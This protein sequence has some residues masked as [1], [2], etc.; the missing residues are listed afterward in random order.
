MTIAMHLCGGQRPTL[1]V[2]K[3][4][5]VLHGP[6]VITICHHDWIFAVVGLFLTWILW[7]E[8]IFSNLP[9]NY[10]PDIPPCF[11]GTACI[12]SSTLATYSL[13]VEF[14]SF[15]RH[16]QK[17]FVFKVRGVLLDHSNSKYGL[18]LHNILTIAH[19]QTMVSVK[20]EDLET[21]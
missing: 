9:L 2:I 20:I 21:K 6:G 15:F 1:D 4:Q 7:I 13:L 17:D 19:F 11:H 18:C 14:T 8:C 12:C 3:C 10:L 5:P 16:L